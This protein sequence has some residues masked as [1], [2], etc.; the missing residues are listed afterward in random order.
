MKLDSIV[1]LYIILVILTGAA[2]GQLP[3]RPPSTPL[4]TSK[5]LSGAAKLNPTDV[6]ILPF[7]REQR[8]RK[9]QKNEPQPPDEL[10]VTSS[11]NRIHIY[12]KKK[13]D[14][15][16]FEGKPGG[17]VGKLVLF[18]PADR[19]GSLTARLPT[20]EDVRTY[21]AALELDGETL[22]TDQVELAARTAYEWSVKSE[23]GTTQLS[24]TSAGK[25]IVSLSAPTD[26]VKGVG[27]ASTVRWGGNEADLAI[28]VK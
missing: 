7:L 5:L 9:F 26:K 28:T 25:D 21:Y 13:A 16:R 17:H 27:F 15:N 1:H 14:G 22:E 12:G 8:T 20:A 23:N 11:T 4:A 6:R 3:Q 2:R 19:S 24:I 10:R 18:P